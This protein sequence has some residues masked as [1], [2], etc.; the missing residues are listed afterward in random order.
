MRIRFLGGTGEVGRSAVL[1]EGGGAK[2][3][4][5]YGVML[6]DEPGF[7]MHVPPRE[8]DA[9]VI[10]HAH[11]DHSGATPIFYIGRGVP[12]YATALTFELTELLLRDFIN[13]SGYYIPFE[14]LELQNMLSRATYLSYGKALR[15]KGMT[16]KLLRAGHIP[17]SA[18]VIVEADGKR[19]LYTGDIN[20]VDTRLLKGADLDY[21]ELDAII[22]ESTYADQDHPRRIEVERAFVSRVEEVIEAGGTVLVPAFAV[23]RAQEVACILTA[24]GFPYDVVMDGMARR[25]NLIFMNHLYELKDPD[26]FMATMEG[27]LLVVKRKDRKKFVKRPCV[28][29]SPAGMLKGGPAAYYAM[30]LAGSSRNAIFLVSYQIPGTPGHELLENKLYVVNGKI[31]QVKAQ[32]ERFDLSSHAGMSDLHYI[33]ASLEGS[34]KVF[35]VHGAEGNCERLA[36]WARE[37]LGLDAVAP[38]A[39]SSFSI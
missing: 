29:I 26:L 12:I 20:P 16:I 19:L 36:T 10:T 35:T 28:I 2:V 13:L 7:P 23:A 6:D 27:V 37:E 22:I 5:D 39:G 1:V 34:P 15:V 11:L 24:H 17:G 32:V 3:L 4:L 33:L 14:Y 30:K 18:Q 38:E 31:Q 9:I 21:G 25:V 8:L